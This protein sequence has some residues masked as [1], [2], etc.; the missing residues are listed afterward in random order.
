MP[1]AKKKPVNRNRLYWAEWGNV[2]KLL[3]ETQGLDSK[4]L[5][6]ERKAIHE[7]VLG[8]A[9]S[10]KTI[11]ANNKLLDQVLAAFRAISRPDDMH[12]QLDALNQ[13]KKRIIFVIDRDLTTIGA[14]RRYLAGILQRMSSEGAIPLH[15]DLYDYDFPDLQRI[16]T[17]VKRTRYAKARKQ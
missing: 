11:V 6:A 17:A 8:K 15:S 2:R 12:P 9:Y 4:D 13:Q 14:D 7:R 10:S 3:Q 5:E 1:R 16:A